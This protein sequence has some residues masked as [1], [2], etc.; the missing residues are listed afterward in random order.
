MDASVII[1]TPTHRIFRSI[2]EQNETDVAN[3][4]QLSENLLDYLF[5][6][7]T[8]DSS[9]IMD[10][11]M[12]DNSII[13]NIVNIKDIFIISPLGLAF[14]AVYNEN[15]NNGAI[16]VKLHQTSLSNTNTY[17]NT[18]NK[19]QNPTRESGF[20][21]DRENINNIADVT[22]TTNLVEK[23][24][25][26][27]SHIPYT[28]IEDIIISIDQIL[29]FPFKSISSIIELLCMDSY[30]ERI[31]NESQSM[32][33]KSIEEEYKR[34]LATSDASSVSGSIRE[35]VSSTNVVAKT[36]ELTRT[37]ND[38]GSHAG[39]GGTLGS[40]HMIRAGGQEEL[41]NQKPIKYK[42][43]PPV[44]NGLT[45][46]ENI[47]VLIKNSV[48]KSIDGTGTIIYNTD[49]TTIATNKDITAIINNA[50]TSN[51]ASLQFSPYVIKSRLP[52]TIRLRENI[53]CN[54]QVTLGR[55]TLF[56]QGTDGNK[57]SEFPIKITVWKDEDK[58]LIE[59]INEILNNKKNIDVIMRFNTNIILLN[60]FNNIYELIT[61]PNGYSVL[62]CTLKGE[63]NKLIEVCSV[64]NGNNEAK[65]FPIKALMYLDKCFFTDDSINGAVSSTINDSG[66]ST[67]AKNTE[68]ILQWVEIEWKIENDE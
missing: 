31:N 23:L 47:Q 41:R 66:M 58:Y 46:K 21:I 64:N 57:T 30:T 37:G 51:K 8:T 20:L 11:N 15:I 18:H 43:T 44:F 54:K 27:L 35:G 40:S 60:N 67:E 14:R 25:T 17:S 36:G 63:E 38:W 6:S 45:I 53:P 26:I 59:I 50:F 3:L 55:Y 2:N 22:D 32:V 4:I 56:T 61:S 34:A 33:K 49:D 48:I 28:N 1:Y 24:T 68:P 29:Y 42:K 9:D 13:N 10:N 65:V 19:S 5:I 52:E 12:L 7:K 16:F 62:K 39:T